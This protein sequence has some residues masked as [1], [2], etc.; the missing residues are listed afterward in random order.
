M[1]QPA[2]AA[3]LLLALLPTVARC[4]STNETEARLWFTEFDAK[5][6]VEKNKVVEA[7]W[8]NAVNLTKENAQKVVEANLAHTEFLREQR[9][10]MRQRFDWKQFSDRNLTRL[11]DKADDIGTSAANASMQ[12]RYGQLST[13]MSGI[14][15]TAQVPHPDTGKM[16]QLDPDITDAL[17]DPNES[18][19]VKRA[20]WQGWR[21]ASGKR[22]RQNYTDFVTMGNLMIREAGYSNIAQYW[23]SW[24]EPR[25]GQNFTDMMAKLWDVALPFYQQLHAYVRRKL[26]DKYGA[27][28][29][30]ETGHIP[31]HL[32]GNMWAQSWFNVEK[33]T[34]PFP[35]LS[36]VDITEKM[37][38]LGWNATK[39]FRVSEEFFTSIGLDPM[40]DTFWEKS[41]LTRLPDVKM[42]CHASAWDFYTNKGDFR[43][44]QCTSITTNYLGT[45]HHEMGHVQY[46]QQYEKQPV[47][48]RR[49]ANPGFHEAVG[50]TLELA[51]MTPGHLHKIG[52]LDEI[53]ESK[54]YY[55]NYLFQMALQKAAF[56]PFGYLIDLWRWQASEGRLAPEKYNE[57]WW[58]L[59]CGLQG[60]SSP[61]PRSEDDFDPGAKYHV[62]N[63]TPYIRYFVSHF[64]QFQLYEALCNISGH[65]GPLYK[66][67]FYQNKQAGDALKKFLAHGSSLHWEDVLS[68]LTGTTEL[69]A[70]SL[71]RYFAELNEFLTE[72]NKK[73]G[74]RVG[75]DADCP[76]ADWYTTTTSAPETTTLA[77]GRAATSGTVGWWAAVGAAALARR[78]LAV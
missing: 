1:K 34:T 67:D 4:L 47:L 50:D 10:E 27:E 11:F 25:P 45:T 5:L 61:V 43:I 32:L 14:Y 23:Q 17:A 28:L 12:E 15:S 9:A 44:K 76:S 37:N 53:I 3:V 72:E 38:K 24:Y 49:G 73:S 51:V 21:D 8:A 19:R 71:V 58:K 65:N 35:D 78:L 42:V 74:E 64:L 39:M 33:L 69:R 56:I 55:L 59:R 48:Y 57:G 20:L 22:M 13:Q 46:Y 66:C 52:L 7:S 26:R 18:E 31:A 30:P 6:A 2:L 77:A 70:D 41:V 40:T 36:T 62:P 75:W 29:F 63:N 54:D 60:V 68:E 16:M